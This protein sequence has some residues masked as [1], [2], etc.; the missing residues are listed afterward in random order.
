VNLDRRLHAPGRRS[1]CET[2]RGL[3]GDAP[4]EH[5]RHL[6]G[7]PERQLVGQTARAH[8]RAHPRLHRPPDDLRPAPPPAQTLHPADPR[9]QRYELTSEGRRLAVFLTNTYTR[10]VN[11]SLADLDPALPADIPQRAPFAQTWRAFEKAL[12]ARIDQAA[13]IA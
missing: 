13:I 12:Q 2:A 8:R 1:W 10:I 6:V 4:A 9:T 5:D 3:A 11:P 7:A